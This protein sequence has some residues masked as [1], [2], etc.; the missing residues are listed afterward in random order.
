MMPPDPPSA[1]EVKNNNQIAT[2][3]SK[4]GVGWQESIDD[5]TT[6][7]MMADNNKQ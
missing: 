2:R 7:M 5:H 3:A 4:V 6:M 1:G